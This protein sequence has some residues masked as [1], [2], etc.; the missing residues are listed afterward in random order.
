MLQN[1]TD[2]KSRRFIYLSANCQTELKII[3]LTF[4]VDSS[5]KKSVRLTTDNSSK[6]QMLGKNKILTFKELA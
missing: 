5:A 3:Y 6:S 2:N 4:I 1:G